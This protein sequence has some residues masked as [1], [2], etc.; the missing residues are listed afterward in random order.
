V[1]F[2]NSRL[3]PDN[4][5]ERYSEFQSGLAAGADWSKKTAPVK[6]PFTFLVLGSWPNI[7]RQVVPEGI[8]KIVQYQCCC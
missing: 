1:R 3:D 6:E 8:V 2:S 5:T 7:P 4:L